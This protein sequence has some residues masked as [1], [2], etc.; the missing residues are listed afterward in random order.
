MPASTA[1][2]IPSEVGTCPVT[3]MPSSCARVTIAVTTSGWSKRVELHLLEP[4]R[5]IP[6]DDGTAGFWRAGSHAAERVRRVAID[7]TG[8]QHARSG[9]VLRRKRITHRDEIPALATHVANGRHASSEICRQPLDLARVRV[10]V[11]ES[12]H[13]R[14]AARVDLTHAGRH[15]DLRARTDCGD[16]S[17]ANDDRRVVDRRPARSV[18]DR[19]ARQRKCAVGDGRCLRRHRREILHRVLHGDALERRERVFQV[20]PD[21]L[22]AAGCECA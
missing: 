17:I 21:R 2:R 3:V 9:P 10:H 14:L 7:E 18:D 20:L 1:R 22:R 13:D 16:P 15:D 5:V 12:G 6:I 11:P 19:R 4:I 8:E